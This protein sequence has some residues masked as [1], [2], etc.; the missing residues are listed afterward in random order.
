VA[1]VQTQLDKFT[2]LAEQKFLSELA[3]AQK[4]DE[5]LDQQGRLQTIERGITERQRD[6]N[7]MQNEL[8]QIRTRSDREREQ[9][10]RAVSEIEGA[11][12]NTEAQRQFVV[13][14]PQAGTVTAI[15]AELG[16]LATGSPLLTILPADATLV[17]QLFA[18]SNAVGFIEANQSVNLRF[19]AFPYQKFGQYQGTVTSVSKVALS[20]SELPQALGS[21]PG[22]L[23]S[24]AGSNQG[25]GDGLYRITVALK[26]QSV[27]TYGGQTQL[28][29]GMQLEAD[30]LQ[31]TRR[32]IEWVLEPLFSLRGK[33]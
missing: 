10:A 15:V 5:W 27:A 17:A 28:T 21:T 7:A 18:P 8:S 12:I 31:D 3:L 13:T 29:A 16:Q 32:L 33:A 9:L 23:G 26:E 30:I 25:A 22:A 11:S 14:A 2:S 1:S 20:P 19:A 24:T 6:K 4:R